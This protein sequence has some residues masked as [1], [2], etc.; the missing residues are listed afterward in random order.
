MVGVRSPKT[1]RKHFEAELASGMAEANAV[2]ARVA[3]EMAVSGGF[4]V[5]S[6][7]WTNV[8]APDH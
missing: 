1:L 8:K 6:F 3:S 5:M 4:P 2:V 7:F